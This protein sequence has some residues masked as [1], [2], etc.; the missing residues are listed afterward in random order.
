MA[1]MLLY[2]YVKRSRYGGM[3]YRRL[4]CAPSLRSLPVFVCLL[5]SV[6]LGP[7][8]C[9]SLSAAFVD[10]VHRISVVRYILQ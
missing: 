5:L 9:L 2:I 6:S 3:K 4:L 1:E 10:C 7:F 8:L